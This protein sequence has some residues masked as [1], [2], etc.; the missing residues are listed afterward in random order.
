[1]TAVGAFEFF[2]ARG[3]GRF[4]GEEVAEQAGVVDVGVLE[5]RPAIYALQH[6]RS[7]S[8]PTPTVLQRAGGR[9]YRK[10]FIFKREIRVGCIRHSGS[11]R[12]GC[13]VGKA[14]SPEKV[15]YR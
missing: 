12:M 4:G 9:M 3:E 15:S 10:R 8:R 1:V 5:V 11:L 2:A 7:H 14:S 13:G 6:P